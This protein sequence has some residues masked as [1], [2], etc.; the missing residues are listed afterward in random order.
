MDCLPN[1]SAWQGKLLKAKRRQCLYLVNTLGQTIEDEVVER[2]C[3]A[4]PS[5]DNGHQRLCMDGQPLQSCHA[6]PEAEAFVRGSLGHSFLA[7]FLGALA[8]STSPSEFTNVFVWNIALPDFCLFSG[9]TA[10][11][12]RLR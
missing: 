4:L 5:F 2:R 11:F 8:S 12:R 7:T 10:S 3:S 9:I 6:D 1:S